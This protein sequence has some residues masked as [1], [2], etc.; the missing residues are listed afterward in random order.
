MAG[1]RAATL[2][3]KK[4]HDPMGDRAALICDFA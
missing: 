2:P 3:Q 1:M 4:L